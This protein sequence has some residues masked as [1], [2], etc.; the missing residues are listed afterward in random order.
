MPLKKIRLK[1]IPANVVVLG[2]VSF[3]TDVSG[4]MIYPLLPIFLTQTLGAAQSFVGLVEGFAES[5]AAFF[6]LVSGFWADRTK[7]RSRLVLGGYSLSSLSRPLVA[8]AQSPW[9][10]F[11]VRFSDRLGKG[12]RTSPR[13]ALIADSIDET[14]RGKAYG[15]QRSLDHAGAVV[16]PVTASLLLFYCTKNLRTIFWVAAVPGLLAVLLIGWKVR[17]V[18]PA[19][20]RALAK[21]FRLTFP[22][23][24]KLKVY[25]AILFLFILSCSSDAFLLLRAKEL[26]IAAAL[27]PILWMVLNMVKALT[28][29]PFGIL[30]DKHGRRRVILAGWLIYTLVYAGFA[31]ASKPWHAWA[32]FMLYGFFYGLTEGTEAALLVD[33]ANP[34]ERGQ[35][36]GWY[37]FVIG[38]GSLPASLLFGFIWQIGG[39]KTAFLASAAVS[40]VSALSLFIFL[41]LVPSSAKQALAG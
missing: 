29:L 24:K 21:P 32:L 34:N 35:A 16:G 23:S 40:A 26:G 9:V 27:L 22:Q 30:S 37:Y 10:V 6:T 15:L 33:Y 7:D 19:L 17:E 2:L 38:L 18:R 20:P 8:L 4:D 5:T 13:D 3:L 36:F 11:F 1:G 41:K 25:L 14:V 28:T 31:L 39:S 12:I